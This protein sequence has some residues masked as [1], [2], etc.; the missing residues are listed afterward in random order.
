[1]KN[2]KDLT[3]EEL[4]NL[5]DEE[6][7]K[8]EKFICAENGIKLLKE[9]IMPVPDFDETKDLEI[10][11]VNGFGGYVCFTD[12]NEAKALV[13][14]LKKFNTIG[15][16]NYYN[17]IRYFERGPEKNYD[18]KPVD[19]SISSEMIC[20]KDRAIKIDTESKGYKKVKAKYDTDFKEYNEAVKAQMAAI[21]EFRDIYYKAVD[22][23][24]NRRRLCRIYY[25]DY[26]PLAEGN[27]EMAMSFL[28]KAYPLTEEDENYINN[29]SNEDRST[30]NC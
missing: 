25:N 17:N 4:A 7:S 19:I 6:I 28:K 22:I 16:T 24:E 8:Y 13:D 10:F 14:Y 30:G 21:K 23:I 15:T 20:T 9:P 27:K 12:I 5:T 26:L 11:R 18:G 2:W 1:M 29:Q 3:D